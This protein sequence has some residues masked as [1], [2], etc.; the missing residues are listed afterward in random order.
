[1]AKLE[2]PFYSVLFIAQVPVDIVPSVVY[3]LEATLTLLC[4]LY[5]I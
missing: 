1:M 2:Q 5:K 3:T 4:V